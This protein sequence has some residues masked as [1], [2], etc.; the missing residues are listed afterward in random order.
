MIESILNLMEEEGPISRCSE[1]KVIMEADNDDKEVKR[2]VW[3]PLLDLKGEP[4]L[5]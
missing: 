2:L 3:K 1:K 4:V 5:P